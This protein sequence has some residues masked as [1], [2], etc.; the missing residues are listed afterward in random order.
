MPSRERTCLV[1]RYI[2]RGTIHPIQSCVNAEKSIPRVPRKLAPSCERETVLRRQYLRSLY[3]LHF[4]RVPF[5]KRANETGGEGEV[6][7][8]SLSWISFRGR[9]DFLTKIIQV[10]PMIFVPIATDC[11]SADI[12][13]TRRV[14]HTG[15]SSPCIYIYTVR[16]QNFSKL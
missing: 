4:L 10:P 1:Q 7:S 12:E 16:A 9:N 6:L 5:A 2:F 3:F 13:I 14:L 8:L 15:E 11:T